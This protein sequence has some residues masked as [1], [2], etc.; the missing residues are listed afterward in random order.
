VKGEIHRGG[1]DNY[2]SKP[3]QKE[4]SPRVLEKYRLEVPSGSYLSNRDSGS[5]VFGVVAAKMV[6][7]G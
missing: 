1:M 4:D 6:A 2:I 3:V 7:R 5:V